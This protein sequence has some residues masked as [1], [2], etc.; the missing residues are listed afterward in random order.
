MIR[1]ALFLSLLAPAAVAGAAELTAIPKAYHGHWGLTVEQCK[2]GKIDDAN[3]R[4]DAQ[5]FE[6]YSM[7]M[8]VRSVTDWSTDGHPDEIIV[9]G[10]VGAGPDG[11]D[12]SKR[13]ALLENRTVLAVGEGEDHS[14]YVRCKS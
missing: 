11:Y 4:V 3:V 14:L 6:D 5:V 13:L 10:R 1:S 12:Y 8:D 7:K 9:G 2:K